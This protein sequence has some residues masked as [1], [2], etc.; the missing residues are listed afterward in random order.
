MKMVTK[1]YTLLI[2][3]TFVF[4]ACEGEN[5]FGVVEDSIDDRPDEGIIID[6]IK[7]GSEPNEFLEKTGEYS[8]EFPSTLFGDSSLQVSADLVS[9]S[10]NI[11]LESLSVDG[12]NQFKQID[13]L[14]VTDNRKQGSSATSHS[15]TTIQ[16]NADKILDIVIVID[17]S[18]SMKQEQENLASKLSPLL[19]NISD[20]DWRISV[21]TTDPNEPCQVENGLIQNSDSDLN[22]R[23]SNAIQQGVK[24]GGNEQ[25][26]RRAVTGLQPCDGIPN[27][28]RSDSHIA[29][30]IVSDE[31][32]CSLNGLG[33]QN[34]P[35]NTEQ[36]LIDHLNTS[37][38]AGQNA[39]VY[40][41]FKIPGDTSCVTAPYEGKVY[42]A[43]VNATGGHA[44]SIC[45]ND[46]TSTL[47]AI[48]QDISINFNKVFTLDFTPNQSSLKVFINNIQSPANDYSVISNVVTFNQNP[49]VS[50]ASVRFEYNYPSAPVVSSFALS[51]S[52]DPSTLAVHINGTKASNYTVNG[53][54]LLFD[55]APAENAE[56]LIQYRV[57]TPLNKE[58]NIAKNANSIN[59]KVNDQDNSDYSYN[60][61]SGKLTFNNAPKD[62]ETI[63]VAY[64]LDAGPKLD[65]NVNLDEWIQAPSFSIKDAVS[66]EE[67]SSINYEG[68]VLTFSADQWS[69]GKVIEI[70]STAVNPG[71]NKT[72]EL[73]HIPLNGLVSIVG[74][75]LS[76]STSDDSA[77]IDGSTLDLNNCPLEDSLSDLSI[78]YEYVEE[79]RYEFQLPPEALDDALFRVFDV[80]INGAQYS[81]YTVE[82]SNL[83]IEA[84]KIPIGGV[85]SLDV[86]FLD[87]A[88]PTVEESEADETAEV[89]E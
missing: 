29:V 84:N 9:F 39:K 12:N 17:N 70:S 6:I 34:K 83:I 76:C 85:I 63:L 31:D 44:G 73:P 75:G 46:Y 59:V 61:T 35:W 67:L 82:D 5:P 20:S 68:G 10:Q 13:R 72:I 64:L 16:E 66:G 89:S 65:Y 14:Q 80:K 4:T 55:S 69:V 58:Y 36:Y 38:V 62:N 86:T 52:A 22:S 79:F 81:D 27:W 78:A 54:E 40:G 21:I 45:D 48:S 74:D 7:F 8:T 57:N 25:G 71:V 56:I 26:I 15:E 24:G 33:C 3:S 41:L 87:A 23:F 1:F 60:P 51:E 50:G 42:N 77:S 18:G 43:A 49:P 28:V 2:L 11:T 19:S 37:R 30:I 47:S 88:I 32:N 53:K